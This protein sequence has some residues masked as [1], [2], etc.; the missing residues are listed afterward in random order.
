MK[1]KIAIASFALLALALPNPSRAQFTGNNQTNIISGVTS[2]WPGS[3]YVGSNYVFDAL[4]ILN[5][6][7]LNASGSIGYTA[8]AKSN[9]VVVSGNGSVWNTGSG[10]AVG[11]LGA[12]NSLL[13]SNGGAVVAA[14]W[15]PLDYGKSAVGGNGSSSS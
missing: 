8:T 12:G 7:V 3:Y 4:F 1:T 2:N 14:I 5:G 15:S 9:A 6:G 11:G 10:L 13:I